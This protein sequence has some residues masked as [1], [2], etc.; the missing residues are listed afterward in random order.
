MTYS[1][2]MTEGVADLMF[3]DSNLRVM[4]MTSSHVRIPFILQ[5]QGS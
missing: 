4:H 1:Y 3:I 5:L 2:K